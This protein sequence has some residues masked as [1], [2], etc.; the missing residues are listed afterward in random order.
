MERRDGTERGWRGRT[1]HCN[2]KPALTL[3][4]LGDHVV[5]EAMLVPD[6]LGFEIF[7]VLLLVDVLEH[8]L[9]PPVILLQDRV[10]GA[11][12]QRQLLVERK[13]EARMRK[14]RDALRRVIHGHAH[15]AARPEI[16]HLDRLRF[17]VLG[18]E[19]HLKRA[20]AINH[21]IL[22]P[23]LVPKRMA[24]DNN[25]LLPARHEARDAGDDDGL[26]EDG[27]AEDVADGAVGGQPHLLEVELLDARFVGGDGRAFDADG[28]LLDGFGGV[29]G[30]LVV[31]FVAVREAEVV[32]FEVDVEVAGGAL[33]GWARWER[34]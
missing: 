7:P 27:A 20:L 4:H 10:L 12:I 29:D 2:D 26:A 14:P 24:P 18:R 32:V 28:V 3:D 15:S 11:H 30:D 21:H 17:P 25:R 33:V 19:H 13:L 9:E 8:V 16:K 34:G 23:V 31:G 1:L 6:P 5:D 22:G